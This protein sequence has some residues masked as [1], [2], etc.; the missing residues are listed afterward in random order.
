MAFAMF[1]ANLGARTMQCVVVYFYVFLIFIA[2][3]G[4]PTSLPEPFK[5]HEKTKK[6][7]PSQDSRERVAGN[8]K[9]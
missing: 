6:K 1:L 4:P 5:N 3:P 9:H 8:G 2:F 7:A